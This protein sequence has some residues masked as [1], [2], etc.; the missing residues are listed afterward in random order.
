VIKA[1][2]FFYKDLDKLRRRFLSAGDQ[3]I[4]GGSAR[5]IGVVSADLSNMEG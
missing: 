2:I 5:L 3:E 1:P 4:H